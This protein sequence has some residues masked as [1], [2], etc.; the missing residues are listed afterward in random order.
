MPSRTEESSLSGIVGIYDAADTTFL[1]KD[2]GGIGENLGTYNY[3]GDINGDGLNDIAITA[4][5]D[6]STGG[7]EG[8]GRVH[9]F[10][11]D[12]ERFDPEIDLQT[13]EADQ[14]IIGGAFRPP[15]GDSVT[16][17]GQSCLTNQMET[18][19]FNN[20]GYRD[21]VISVP[22]LS[23]VKQSMIIW[24]QEG[25][26][27]KE[28]EVNLSTSADLGYSKTV[29]NLGSADVFIPLYLQMAS[30]RQVSGS[31]AGGFGFYND[32]TFD[33]MEVEDI[34]GDGYDDLISGGFITSHSG[35]FPRVFVASIYWGATG[36][37]TSFFEE[38][39]Y[40]FLGKSIDV[41][42][43]DGD[44]KFDLVIGAPSLSKEW[45]DGH[46]KGAV[47][48]LFNLLQYEDVNYS[49]PRGEYYLPLNETWDTIIWGS[50]DFD[51]FGNKVMLRDINGDG[52]DDIIAGA[53]YA[54]GPADLDTNCG[55][56]YVFFGGDPNKFP[57]E[58]D[59]DNWA[60]SIILGD[61]GYESEP[62][63]IMA[64]S[65]G[66]FF[67]IG[68]INGDGELEFV[69]SLP[70][71]DLPP[72]DGFDRSQAGL[73]ML[74]NLKEVIPPGGAIIKL[75]NTK[76]TA[77]I[78]GSDMG[79]I[80][81]QQLKVIDADNDGL[82]DITFSAPFADGKDN[83]RPRSGEVYMIRGKGLVINDIEAWGSAVNGNDLFLGGG[84][85]T[86]KI[87]YR[88]TYGENRTRGGTVTL[89]P[90][91][92][93][94]N[95]YFSRGTIQASQELADALDNDT[96][97][98]KWTGSG[99]KGMIEI[100]L[101]PGWDLPGN[102]K[103]NI[104][105]QL[106]TG[107]EL[108]ISRLFRDVLTTR[109]SVRLSGNNDLYA[110]GN[111]IR[112]PDHWFDPGDEIAMSGLYP[113]YSAD[114]TRRAET[115]PFQLVLKN[116][117]MKETDRAD[118]EETSM[119]E[120][121]LSGGGEEEKTYLIEL[122]PAKDVDWKFGPPTTGEP[123]A[124]LIRIDGSPPS[125]PSG[126]ELT[127]ITG[128]EGYSADGKFE[129]EWEDGL[130]PVGDHGGS[131]VKLYRVYHDNQWEIP[132]EEGGLQGTYY[133]DPEFN[134]AGLERLDK[135]IDF[136]KWGAWGPEPNYIPPIDYSVRWHGWFRPDHEYAQFLRIIGKGEAKLF[137][138]GEMLIDWTDLSKFPSAGPLSLD[139]DTAYSLE[140]YYRS[141]TGTSAIQL[142]Y[143]DT[144]G[145][146]QKA[147]EGM[148]LHPSNYMRVSTTN[149]GIFDLSVQAVDWTGKASESR[150]ASGIVDDDGPVIDISDIRPWYNS[151]S[152]EME[153][154]I[155]D[156]E[157]SS[158][159]GTNLSSFR[160]RTTD[161]DDSWTDWSSR[162]KQLSGEGAKIAVLQV[163]LELTEDWEGAIQFH[164]EDR[165]GNP[166]LTRS[167]Q[168][169]IDTKPPEIEL[170]GPEHK[171]KQNIENCNVSVIMRDMGGSGVDPS[172]IML[173][174]SMG[175]EPYSEWRAAYTSDMEGSLLA[176]TILEPTEGRH[177]VQ[178]RGSDSVGNTAASDVF[179]YELY[180]PPVNMPPV[181]VIKSP[182]D[183][184]VIRSGSPVVLDAFGTTD[185]GLGEYDEVKLTWVSSIDGVLGTGNRLEVYLTTGVHEIRLYADDGSPGHN[186]S[187]FVTINVEFQEPDGSDGDNERP[188]GSDD[189]TE[190][191]KVIMT[192]IAMCLVII[193]ILAALVWQYRKRASGEVNVGISGEKT[194]DDMEYRDRTEEEST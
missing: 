88:N 138:D 85:L 130:G 66:N 118:A 151:T 54:D 152:I 125:S 68:D 8:D 93:D 77:A 128:Y 146:Y 7:I 129:I 91:D 29:L 150:T 53:P 181:P 38:Q 31:T 194:E 25:G 90:D 13:Q 174:T 185:D 149:D 189:T 115:G 116:D 73:V 92:I 39:P 26:W 154:S 52:F 57:P 137:L 43:I 14:I 171:T 135:A 4:P 62:V 161:E 187:T 108:R 111:R 96:I 105:V 76:G 144:R 162:A 3:I 89:F 114:T 177:R 50:G 56:I 99:E 113:V 22:G 117:E 5:N 175:N 24:G 63:E 103:M 75:S 32:N 44:G 59:A 23:Y 184:T 127:S 145:D 139:M 35:I 123:Y 131:G 30:K 186:I 87:P 160:Y 126:L 55:Q 71:K 140:V 70:N 134:T 98:M 165:I 163:K 156:G 107:S 141:R 112:H 28:M 65:L 37:T 48:V 153:L 119:L 164:V 49:E 155:D 97:K 10:Y 132:R 157:L 17:L 72:N 80:L 148:L 178:F 74:Y 47:A 58:M 33:F 183:G 172:T 19:D 102:R 82:D 182:Q 12:G 1:G 147:T 159:T 45:H 121:E 142:Q 106:E 191:L 109:R 6:P 167:V 67:D 79:D 193:V 20:D 60:D 69:A 36:N 84:E 120:D 170:V 192:A 136:L 42:D 180:K 122:Q 110:N 94:L 83:A 21:L 158:N 15:G 9:I 100:T 188:E 18:G 16:V 2:I 46:R 179:E 86:L 169:G 51:W 143:K 27:P 101:E 168:F 166:T 81:G 64:D 95:I 173:R 61:Q 176:W 104:E 34:D 190:M 41:G 124:Q 11:G 40:S 133:T 78:E